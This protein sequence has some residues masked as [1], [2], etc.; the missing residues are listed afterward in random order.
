MNLFRFDLSNMRGDIFGGLT[1][2]VVALPLA[3]A[4]GEASGAGPIAGLWGAIFVGFFAAFLGGTGAQVSGPTGPMIVVFAGVFASLSGE[5]AL[6]FGAVVLAGLLQ[7]LFGVLRFGDY[8]R[9]VPYPVISGFMSG[10]GCIIIALQVARLFGH[11]PAD[12]GTIPALTAIP[13]AV[14]DP[15]WSALLVGALSLGIIFLWPA[16]WG[17]FLPGPLAA[18][19]TGTLVAL[20]LPGIPILGDIPTG[21]PSFILPEFSSSTFLLVGEA[22]LILA[23]LGAIDSLLT[24]LVADNMTQTRHDSN[25]ELIGQGVGN[26]FAGLFGAIPG[27]GAT[28]RTVVNI[29]TGGRTRISGMIHAL[30]LVAVV[31]SL[32]PLAANIPHAVLAGILIK[33]GYDIID[34]SYL[35]RAHKG[36]RWDLALMALVLSLTVF[37]DLITAVA[38]GVVLAALAFVKRLADEQL[39]NIGG[40]SDTV[41]LSAE[42]AAIIADSK[43]RITLFQ[44]DGPMSFGAAADLGHQVRERS[45]DRTHAI[46]LDF[47]RIPFVD[48][49]ASRA[50]ETIVCDARQAGKRVF[51][52]GMSEP[53]RKVLSGLNSIHCLPEDTSFATRLDALKASALYLEGMQDGTPP[54][55]LRPSTQAV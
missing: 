33:V 41:L 26:T 9:L 10:I 23:V 24:S 11:E 25:K 32:A 14:L 40:D 6:V 42:E 19:I 18:L 34:F 35:R 44:F 36:P 15:N 50:V 30:I 55:V 4:F 52:A 49:S 51:V 8:I 39:R 46:V 3:L 53:V 38:A 54:T 7:I 1:A 28:M 48:V 17:R 45:R 13:G 37:V 22:A 16:S 21:L 43:G 29:R 12:G 31:V 5:P 27:A 47:S 2:G 20:A